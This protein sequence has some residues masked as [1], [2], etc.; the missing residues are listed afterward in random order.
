MRLAREKT[1]KGG[2]SGD[3]QKALKTKEPSKTRD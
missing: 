3:H 2:L 1:D